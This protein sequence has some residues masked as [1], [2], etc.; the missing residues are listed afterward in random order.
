MC[1]EKSGRDWKLRVR[2]ILDCITKIM[3]YTAGMR[4]D[5]FRDDPKTVDAVIRNLEVIGEAAGYIP[6]EI[7]ERFP[8]ISWLEMRGMRNI[9][10]H[11]YFGVSLPII[12]HTIENDLSPLAGGLQQMLTTDTDVEL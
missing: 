1:A 3:N 6:L 11:Q 9:L 2:D 12:W 4:L 8:D 7:Q 10:V 5:D